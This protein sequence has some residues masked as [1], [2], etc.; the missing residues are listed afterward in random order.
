MLQPRINDCPGQTLFPF[1]QPYC[2][3]CLRDL[4]KASH[5]YQGIN[6]FQCSECYA[7]QHGEEW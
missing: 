4:S 1:M 3:E 5:L 6:G 7:E 2:W